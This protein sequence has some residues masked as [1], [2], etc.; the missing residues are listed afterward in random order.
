MQ[1]HKDCSGKALTSP[2]QL[3]LNGAVYRATP[4]GQPA[5]LDRCGDVDVPGNEHC[6]A[7]PGAVRRDQ[8]SK[9]LVG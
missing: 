5:A 7:P 4:G 6:E 1:D 2:D 3:L 9:P 8:L